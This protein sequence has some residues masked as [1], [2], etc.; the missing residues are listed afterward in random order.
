MKTD[1][2]SQPLWFTFLVLGIWYSFETVDR[3][4]YGLELVIG[5]ALFGLVIDLALHKKRNPSE[6]WDSFVDK[7][8]FFRSQRRTTYMFFF[9][10]I[11]GLLNSYAFIEEP[12]FLETEITEK[13]IS[14]SKSTS[15][16]LIIS[17]KNLGTHELKVSK[18]FWNSH[19][20]GNRLQIEVRENLLGFFVITDYKPT[21]NQPKR[22]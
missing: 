21:S 22:D 20:V 5:A 18:E 2:T 15:H 10:T 6:L 14:R 4:F 11:V 3:T 12:K 1:K 17:P 9:L 8:N 16:I 13:R 7:R 19:S